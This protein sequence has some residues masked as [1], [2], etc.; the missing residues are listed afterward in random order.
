M[1]LRTFVISAVLAAAPVA[2]LANDQV[3]DLTK[4]SDAE[5]V[6]R[7]ETTQGGSD[8]SSCA[9]FVPLFAELTRRQPDSFDYRGRL[10][11]SRIFCASEERRY[12]DGLRL[13]KEAETE[14][15]YE[16][17]DLYALHFATELNDAPELLRR[18]R[19]VTESSAIVDLPKVA[20]A[21]SFRRLS[22]T[23]LR[24]EADRLAS[25]LARSPLYARL[26]PDVQESLATPA[27][28]HAAAMGQTAAADRILRYVRSPYTLLT[29]LARRDFEPIWP[30]LEAHA[31]ENLRK[32]SAG[33]VSWAATRLADKPEDRDRLS[34][35]AEALAFAGRDDEAIAVAQNWL[36][37]SDG[38]GELEEGNGWALQVEADAW[39]RRGD[40]ARADKIFDDLALLPADKHPWVVNFVINRQGRL[41]ELG[42]WE[43]ALAAGAIARTVAGEYGS[44]YARA[45]VASIFGCAHYKLGHIAEGQRELDFL[46]AH[47][48]DYPSGSLLVLQCAGRDDEAAAVAKQLLDQPS[49]R[50]GLLLEFQ[51][52]RFSLWSMRESVLPDSAEL[53]RSRPDL[54]AEALK[55]VRVLP[56][57]LIPAR[58]LKPSERAR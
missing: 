1:R 7:A 55:Y 16:F 9:V 40:V 25:E 36:H 27:L 54:L 52:A 34:R 37:R 58:N 19:A 53:I 48:D 10:A 13:V 20:V 44:P 6:K 31:G 33:Y 42:R 47:A 38:A 51:D 29:M 23:D 18:L 57:R 49:K 2:A 4:L 28:R 14:F 45:A 39:D 3:P 17:Y 8:V 41:L 26:D 32:A 22:Q 50:D 21:A 35:Y 5:L 11:A 24:P 43:E 12:A 46:V 56:D 15:G 30:Q